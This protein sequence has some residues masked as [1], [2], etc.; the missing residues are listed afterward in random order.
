MK[1]KSIIENIDVQRDCKISFAL[2]SS[3]VILPIQYSIII[4]FKLSG[5]YTSSV[6]RALTVASVGVIYLFA[7]PCVLKRNKW[8]FVLIYLSAIT[9]FLLTFVLFPDNRIF[10]RSLVFPMFFMNLPS[11]VYMMSIHDLKVF[12]N[13]MEKAGCLVFAIGIILSILVFSGKATVGN[14]SMGL[15]YYM[16]LPTIIFLDDLFDEFSI[17]SLVKAGLSFMVILSL[18]SR[19]AVLCTIVFIFL[20]YIKGNYKKAWLNICVV[21]TAVG[22]I[23]Y[24]DKILQ[25][26]NKIFLTYGIK[27]RNIALFLK[28]GVHLSGRDRLLEKVIMEI[29]DKPIFGIGIA[30][31]R[32]ILNGTYVHNV[33]IEILSHFGVIL[34]SA[35]LMILI[36]LIF[37]SLLTKNISEYSLIII[38]VSLGLVVLMVSSS[39]LENIKFWIFLGLLININNRDS[40][41][42]KILKMDYP[43]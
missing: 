17:K 6:V 14:Y 31:D 32:K 13:V 11:L 12:R 3:F 30:G 36:I 20:K 25:L 15:S 29:A 42:Q 9:L 16:L 23:F 22:A 5:T 19:G 24:S 37:K 10:L 7:L 41:R 18:G 28:E 26:L 4:L 27:S 39:Y 1:D 43:L 38:W 2:M 21:A 8:N 40:D 33:L 35:I 34:G